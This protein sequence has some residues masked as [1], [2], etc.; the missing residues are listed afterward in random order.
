MA[1]AKLRERRQLRL[2]VHVPGTPPSPFTYL[3]EHPFGGLPST[4]P[5]S[6]IERLAELEKVGV[7]GHCAGGTVYRARHRRTG[8]ELAVKAVRVRDGGG[9]AIREADVHLR[10]AAAAPDHPHVVRL[11]GVFPRPACGDQFLCLVLEYVTNGSLGDVLRRCGRLPE[12][13]IA[14]VAR[15]AL[16]GLR[17]LHRLGVV[18]GDVKPSNL[19]V[20]RHGEIK[21]ADFGA[22]RHVSSDGRAHRT[23]GAGGTCAYMSPERLDPVGFGAAQPSAAANFASDVWALGVVLLECHVGRFPLVAAGE[24]PDC[25]ALVV[26][27]CFGD[28]P[29]VPVAATPEFRSFVR[30]CL[31]KDWRRRATVEELLGHPFVSG[32]GRP[33]CCATNEWLTNFHDEVN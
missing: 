15:C 31:E 12:H 33:P 17:H 2:S 18:H 29:E 13:A 14:G 25:A 11:H 19:L 20:G 26:A 23:A 7:L 30:R 3:P 8:A 22:S 27:V 24:R 4:P 28:A 21:I 5:G 10:V 16:R 6:A 9:A 1:M 32:S